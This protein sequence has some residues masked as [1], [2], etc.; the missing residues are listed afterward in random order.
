VNEQVGLP[1]GLRGRGSEL[2]AD[3]SYRSLLFYGDWS[4]HGA[5]SA[6]LGIIVTNKTRR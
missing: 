6:P 5:A 3:A 2:V 1:T 4:Q